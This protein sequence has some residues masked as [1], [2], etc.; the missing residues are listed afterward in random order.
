MNLKK[1]IDSEPEHHYEIAC[2]YAYMEDLDNAFTYLDES[3]DYVVIA[4]DRFF[5]TP[6]F[7]NLKEDPRWEEYLTR[8]G[9]EFN[10]NFN[11]AL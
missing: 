10:Y 11:A 3:Y 1:H 9:N 8:L 2:L 7:K 6:E 5:T 4:P